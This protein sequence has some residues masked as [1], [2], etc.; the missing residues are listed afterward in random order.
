MMSRREGCKSKGLDG[1][2]KVELQAMREPTNNDSREVTSDFHLSSPD[3]S[4][5]NGLKRGREW[6]QQISRQSTAR[7]CARDRNG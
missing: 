5:E 2:L 1:L 4:V 7:V 3:S 6:N